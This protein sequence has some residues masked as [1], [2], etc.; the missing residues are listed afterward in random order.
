MDI[1]FFLV[2]PI[3]TII[4]AI[5]L[6]K[7]FKSPILVT[8]I[9]FSIFLIVTYTA[10]TSDFLINTI[11]YTIIAY[12]TAVITKIIKYILSYINEEN[13]NIDNGNINTDSKDCLNT[14]DTDSGTVNNYGYR[15]NR[16]RRRF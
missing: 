12:I 2:F 1:L 13:Y 11:V 8:A 10:F 6:Q 3:S 4:I 14:N 15:I 16:F 9:I 5:A 7:I